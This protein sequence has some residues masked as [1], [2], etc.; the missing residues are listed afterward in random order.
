[1]IDI[2]ITSDDFGLLSNCLTSI[3]NHVEIP[4]NVVVVS[5][6]KKFDI[7][8][9]LL[10]G[11]VPFNFSANI[12]IGLKTTENDVLI[13]GSDVEVIDGAIEKLMEVSPKI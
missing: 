3:E 8:Y 6:Y 11:S 9:P 5:S 7:K 4:Y 10:Q 1:L 2:I 12:N 13:V